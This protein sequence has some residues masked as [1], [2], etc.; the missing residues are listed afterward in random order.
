MLLEERRLPADR[1][2]MLARHVRMVHH[3]PDR[4]ALAG[5]SGQRTRGLHPHV[6]EVENKNIAGAG[7]N[8]TNGCAYDRSR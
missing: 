4:I 5:D 8:V 1:A 3:R 6:N 2:R 7:H